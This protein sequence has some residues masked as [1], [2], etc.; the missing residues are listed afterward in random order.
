MANDLLNQLFGLLQGLKTDTANL[1]KDLDE[2]DKREETRGDLSQ[3]FSR[4]NELDSV[5]SQL[6]ESDVAKMQEELKKLT[7]GQEDIFEY[8]RDINNILMQVKK[9]TEKN[10]SAKD[11]VIEHMPSEAKEQ[12]ADNVGSLFDSWGSVLSNVQH[13]I[14]QNTQ[15]KTGSR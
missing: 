2:K 6:D 13:W 3:I 11:K 7:S 10:P 14:E 4:F 1:N 15:Q 5:L 9:R 8:N 12:H